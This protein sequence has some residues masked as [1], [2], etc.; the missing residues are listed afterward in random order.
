M[1]K[2][3]MTF[4]YYFRERERGLLFSTWKMGQIVLLEKKNFEL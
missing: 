3:K 4:I 2:N 1:S